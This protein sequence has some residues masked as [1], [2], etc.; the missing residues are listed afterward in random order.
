MIE[1]TVTPTVYWWN[2]EII[3]KGLAPVDGGNIDGMIELRGGFC[4]A[5]SWQTPI[6]NGEVSPTFYNIEAQSF[7]DKLATHLGKTSAQ[8]VDAIGK[9]C[10]DIKVEID[11]RPKFTYTVVPDKVAPDTEPTPPELGI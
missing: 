3:L 11:A 7:A 8:I 9:A 1:Q 4:T 5:G 10:E 2:N 6:D